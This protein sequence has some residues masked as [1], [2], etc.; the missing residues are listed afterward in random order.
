MFTHETTV[1][2]PFLAG[3]TPL[4]IRL[5]TIKT[6]NK[7]ADQE[8]SLIDEIEFDDANNIAVCTS[9][10]VAIVSENYIKNRDVDIGIFSG[11]GRRLL[12][13]KPNTNVAPQVRKYVARSQECYSKYSDVIETVKSAK[14]AGYTRIV[15]CF[16]NENQIPDSIDEFRSVMKYVHDE[17]CISHVF[18][19]E[20]FV[21]GVNKKIPFIVSL[22]DND[23]YQKMAPFLGITTRL[24]KRFGQETFDG[25]MHEVWTQ[26]DKTE[27]NFI[28]ISNKLSCAD[29]ICQELF[30]KKVISSLGSSTVTI[31]E[32]MEKADSQ[33]LAVYTKST[34]ISIRVSEGMMEVNLP[35]TTATHHIVVWEYGTSTITQQLEVD[36]KCG[37]DL[38]GQDLKVQD[39]M[40]MYLLPQSDTVSHISDVSLSPE[41]PIILSQLDGAMEI[42]LKLL[43]KV[44]NIYTTIQTGVY[45]DNA[46]LNDWLDVLY[47][48][49]RVDIVVR[50]F[51]IFL[52]KTTMVSKVIKKML[53][54]I[55]CQKNPE[56]N[57]ACVTRQTSV[58]LSPPKLKRA[59]FDLND[60][61]SGF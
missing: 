26:Y 14:N 50:R 33:I 32:T 23:A 3:K 25:V 12:H 40:Q 55:P 42:A 43:C 60:F 7:I 61:T 36:S 18:F 57:R 30:G 17:E 13:V 39:V 41:P 24:E 1:S 38:D 54:G 27:V 11:K 48:I 51:P 28:P 22:K 58:A 49:G 59:R 44:S 45:Q 34:T 5:I 16:T 10:E 52:D 19:T 6:E 20:N 37:K 9:L 21:K 31:G 53:E 47:D 35:H 29:R 8:K 46:K 56:P 4:P 15:V 2:E